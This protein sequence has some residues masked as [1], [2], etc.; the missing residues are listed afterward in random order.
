M[1][2]KSVSL[3]VSNTSEATSLTFGHEIW[4]YPEAQPQVG[5]CLI[6]HVR[7]PCDWAPPTGWTRSEHTAW[8]VL[9]GDEATFTFTAIAPG[10]IEVDLVLVRPEQPQWEAEH[11]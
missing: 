6:A 7:C 4:T 9:T 5:D 8:R 3:G 2:I 10:L 11:G 1:S